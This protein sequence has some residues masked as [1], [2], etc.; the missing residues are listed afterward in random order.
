MKIYK[1]RKAC[2]ISLATLTG[3]EY[4]ETTRRG[5]TGV[6]DYTLRCH[7]GFSNAQWA[8]MGEHY[9][10]SPFYK[11]IY[12]ATVVDYI[13]H[14]IFDLYEKEIAHDSKVSGP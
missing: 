12:P 1:A 11:D 4:L 10:Q 13:V 9:Q 8:V 2:C 7:C 5:S 6:G 14:K 3:P